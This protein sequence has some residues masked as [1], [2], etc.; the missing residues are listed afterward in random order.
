MSSGHSIACSI[1]KCSQAVSGD[2]SFSLSKLPRSHTTIPT[3]IFTCLYSTSYP[4]LLAHNTQHS[5]SMHSPN[6]LTISTFY[7]VV[8]VEVTLSLCS[9]C[10]WYHA[11][12]P[13]FTLPQS[14]RKQR[15]SGSSPI[16]IRRIHTRVYRRPLVLLTLIACFYLRA[17][18]VRSDAETICRTHALLHE[19]FGDSRPFSG[20]LFSG[21]LSCMYLIGRYREAAYFLL[22]PT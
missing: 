1:V 13:S 4:R 2:L 21:Q 6:K 3:S 9:R 16:T 11:S 18:G 7:V 22:T 19:M 15:S 14:P 17:F 5:I 20:D 10:A 12:C 8:K